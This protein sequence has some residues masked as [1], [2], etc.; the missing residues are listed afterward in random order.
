MVGGAGLLDVW[1][2]DVWSH[3]DFNLRQDDIIGIIVIMVIFNI[4]FF[5]IFIKIWGCGW[6]H[7]LVE[8]RGIPGRGLFFFWR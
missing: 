6:I 2:N 4:Y 1:S 7:A 3:S 8:S 5:G